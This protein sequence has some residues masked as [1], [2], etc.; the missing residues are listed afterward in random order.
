[1]DKSQH[2]LDD[3]QMLLEVSRPHHCGHSAAKYIL[4]VLLDRIQ[5][6]RLHIVV[7]PFG[8]GVGESS[9]LLVTAVDLILLFLL[10]R[11][12]DLCCWSP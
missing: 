2:L 5:V 1:M 4:T 11:S 7:H 12:T 8:L 10:E 9:S 6:S 3:L